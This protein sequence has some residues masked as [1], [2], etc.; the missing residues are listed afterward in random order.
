MKIYKFRQLLNA[1][2]FCRLK[3]IIETGKF[4]CSNFWELNDP[5]EG[6]FS[7]LDDEEVSKKITE[8]YGEKGQ[9]KICSFSEE[10][11][12]KNPVMWGYYAGG[13]K[14]VAIEVENYEVKKIDYNDNDI[15]LGDNDVL[16]EKIEKILLTKTLAWNH[17]YE[18]RFLDKIKDNLKKI[19]KITAI[20]FGN[21]YGGLI[22]SGEIQKDKKTFEKYKFF[23]EEIID[24]AKNKGIECFDVKI[25]DGKVQKTSKNLWSKDK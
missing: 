7:I 14:G 11:S 19:E 25:I 24:V 10:K 6:V 16:D 15:L 2:D 17:E 8:I 23:K 3:H 22:N 9:Y 4:W 18:Y 12:F 13:F 5:M 21:P 1:T 20:Y